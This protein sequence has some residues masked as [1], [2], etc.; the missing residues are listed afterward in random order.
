MGYRSQGRWRVKCQAN[1]T[2]SHSKFSPCITCPDISDEISQINA[3]TQSIFR[4]NLPVTQFFCGKS[5][6]QLMIGNDLFK[7]QNPKKNLKCLC[8][9]GQN[10]DPQWKKSCEW[11]FM[12]EQWRP[13]GPI[14][15][16]VTCKPKE[17]KLFC[18]AIKS[19]PDQ[20]L[21]QHHI[22]KNGPKQWRGGD[23][24]INHNGKTIATMETGTRTFKH[25]LP[26]EDVDVENDVFQ[27]T[28]F[29]NDGVCIT[30][31]EVNNKQVTVGMSDQPNFWLDGDTPNCSSDIV[32]TPQITIQNGQVTTDN[33]SGEYSDTSQTRP[34]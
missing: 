13:A 20:D 27:L 17:F 8:R 1:N 31:L 24:S 22:A 6:D 30:S 14:V 7:G 10:G 25:C 3:Q 28:N 4:K 11:E 32:A 33:C 21:C 5:S 23:I 9:H 2:W 15:S 34:F 18:I 16:T 29:D 12:G 26:M 19:G